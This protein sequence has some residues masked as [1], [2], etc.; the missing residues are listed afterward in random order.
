MS[1]AEPNRFLLYLC[2]VLLLIQISAG[3]INREEYDQWAGARGM[4]NVSRIHDQIMRTSPKDITSS[5]LW[6]N[7]A[8][9]MLNTLKDK[10]SDYSIN[11]PFDKN[12]G[13]VGIVVDWAEQLKIIDVIPN[14]PAY[15][16]GIQTEDVIVK[17]NHTSV[18]EQLFTPHSK[19]E[20][21]ISI[22]SGLPNTPVHLLIERDGEQLPFVLM[23]KKANNPHEV[24]SAVL[25]GVGYIRLPD[26]TPGA[27][28][29][30][31]SGLSSLFSQDGWN[32]L[33]LDLRNNGGG[34]L[35]EALRVAGIFLGNVIVAQIE[36]EADSLSD[37]VLKYGKSKQFYHG[38]LAVLI[39]N[40]TAS[41]SE[42][43]VA[44]IQHH[45]RGKLIGTSTYG[46]GQVQAVIPFCSGKGDFRFTV[47][48][49]YS[50]NGDVIDGKG[51]NPDIKVDESAAA[52]FAWERKVLSSLY[53]DTQIVPEISSDKAFYEAV[54]FLTET[55]E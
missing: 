21:I 24:T 3:T 48:Q 10:Y 9:A 40:N 5:I 6:Q 28:A 44:A 1:P 31:R 8:S 38:K 45:N 7:A 35:T 26:F 25:N 16:A 49:F 43:L 46:K 11:S 55:T 30:L 14:S 23:R 50:P 34:D 42:L 29:R 52:Q 27:S 20:R 4:A 53:S 54:R 2:V 33:V 51:V 22:I 36:P 41:A 32:G 17:V 13:K 15:H 37:N 12:E 47:T 19:L 18:N 39:N